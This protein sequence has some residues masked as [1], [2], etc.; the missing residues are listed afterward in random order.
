MNQLITI[1]NACC[2]LIDPVIHPELVPMHG[3]TFCN[4]AV[5]IIAE[6]CGYRGF[7]GLEANDIIDLM[8]RT[9]EW[10]PVALGLAQDAA[11]SG[12]LV[13]AGQT[14]QPHGHVCV[15]R[16]GVAGVAGHWPGASVPK[17]LNIGEENFI[18][19]GL[20]FAFRNIPN[21]YV[22]KGL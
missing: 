16:P 13:V 18:G 17:C 6:R 11:N 14:A 1:I 12:Q 9:P 5:T 2:E 8:I 4:D 22:W 10:N 7:N 3:E 21:I 19:R 15:I 20:D